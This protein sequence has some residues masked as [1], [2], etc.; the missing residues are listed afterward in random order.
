MQDFIR[1]LEIK[2]QDDYIVKIDFNDGAIVYLDL[3][4]Y[5]LPNSI[6]LS[7]QDIDIFRKVKIARNGRALEFPFELDFC[8]DSLHEMAN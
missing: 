8:A 1:I 5:F 3:K 2:P 4:K 7:L 6:F